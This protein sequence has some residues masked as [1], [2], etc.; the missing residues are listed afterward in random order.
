MN[1]ATSLI[2][3]A[4]VP[5]AQ[6]LERTAV[7]LEGV[8]LSE[9]LKHAGFGEMKG[10]F[11]GGIG[12]QQVTSMLRDKQA[13]ALTFSGGIGLSASILESLRNRYDD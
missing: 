10:V 9:M 3:T 13:A 12:E 8:F 7:E 4:Q 6:D 11:S 2:L 5:S 1:V